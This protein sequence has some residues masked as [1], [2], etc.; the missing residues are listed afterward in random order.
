MGRQHPHRAARQVVDLGARAGDALAGH[1]GYHHPTVTQVVEV[2][3]GQRLEPAAQCGLIG[4]VSEP[5][6]D[7]RTLRE[8]AA[9]E[10]D[11]LVNTAI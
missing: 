9:D 5:Q 11:R 8:R 2:P 7:V 3:P 4:K 6:D 10:L 1:Q